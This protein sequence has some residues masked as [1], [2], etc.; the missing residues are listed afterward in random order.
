MSAGMEKTSRTDDEHHDE[1]SEPFFQTVESHIE[2]I[3]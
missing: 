1:E 3:G 2:A